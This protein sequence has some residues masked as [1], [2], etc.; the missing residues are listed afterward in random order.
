M[1]ADLAIVLALLA[2]AIAMFAFNR[3]RI[4]A[5]ALIML[6]ALPFTGVITM[7]EC[8]PA[9]AIQISSSSRRFS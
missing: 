2:T 6:T 5:V 1:S 7:G 4:Y 8:L 3:P 9:S